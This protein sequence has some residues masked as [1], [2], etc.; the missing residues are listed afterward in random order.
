[1][2]EF[3]NDNSYDCG[4]AAACTI[5]ASHGLIEAKQDALAEIENAYPP[6][7]MGG[8]WGTSSK[9][10][11]QILEVK[12]LRVQQLET[13]FEIYNA[14]KNG[15]PVVCLLGFKWSGHWVVATEVIGKFIHLSNYGDATIED[16]H[17]MISGWIPRIIGFN[18]RGYI[19]SSR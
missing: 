2:F 17:K 19:A 16:F 9:R 14:V 18:G 3:V 10:V 11:K 8:L 1:M 6:D 4:Q 15:Q 7:V 13:P 5:L 12:G